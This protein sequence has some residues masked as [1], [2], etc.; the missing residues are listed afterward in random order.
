MIAKFLNKQ[1]SS[2]EASNAKLPSPSVIEE[3]PPIQ[4]NPF[5]FYGNAFFSDMYPQRNLQKKEKKPPQVFF[6]SDKAVF[7][8]R[9]SKRLDELETWYRIHGN[10]IVPKKRNYR[11][12]HDFIV[13]LRSHWNSLDT[14][15]QEHLL[16]IGYDPD[17]KREVTRGRWTHTD[18]ENLRRLIQIMKEKEPNNISRDDEIKAGLHEWLSQKRIQIINCTPYTEHYLSD[19]GYDISEWI[20]A[21]DVMFDNLKEY[22]ERKK[23]HHPAH[24]IVNSTK[25]DASFSG[26]K[27]HLTRIWLQGMKN[28]FFGGGLPE[29]IIERLRSIGF[30]LSVWENQK[31]K[32]LANNI[33]RDSTGTSIVKRGNDDDISSAMSKLSINESATKGKKKRPRKKK[34]VSHNSATPVH[35]NMANQ[36]TM[37]EADYD[38]PNFGED[39]TPPPP[40]IHKRAE[41]GDTSTISS[42]GAFKPLPKKAKVV[43][44]NIDVNEFPA[45]VAMVFVNTESNNRAHFNMNVSNKV[46]VYTAI[47]ENKVLRNAKVFNFKNHTAG[48]VREGK[49]KY[50]LKV[51]SK[52]KNDDVQE[53]VFYDFGA[54]GSDLMDRTTRS[55]MV[56]HKAVYPQWEQCGPIVVEM[57]VVDIDHS[58]QMSD[59]VDVFWG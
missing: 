47:I 32:K 27:W 9:Y 25:R 37:K 30:D 10:C 57:H 5:G 22:L 55:L 41:S 13:K 16:S 3:D 34:H 23:E 8:Q 29:E 36:T 18:E 14:T 52:H 1:I 6:T 33:Q 11:N 51:A 45:E 40:E 59:S 46:S 20:S 19:A 2:L 48:A 17:P 56:T 44:H 26:D 54:G 58:D 50:V 35:D 38:A 53:E 12:L 42:T 21:R 39:G 15:I 7:I 24:L 49:K 31:Q 4:L 43:T 28:R